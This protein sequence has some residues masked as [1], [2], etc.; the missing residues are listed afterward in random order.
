MSVVVSF[1]E[2][3][4]GSPGVAA[5]ALCILV[6]ALGFYLLKVRP[7][8]QGLLKSLNSFNR[9][10]E[11][12]SDWHGVRAAVASGGS[13]HA[14]VESAWRE[15]QDR[16]LELPYK[17]RSTPAMLSPPTDIWR[18]QRLLGRSM[19]LQL[20]EAAPNILVG[21]GLLFTFFFLTIA[22]TQAAGALV[23][24]A[25]NVVNASLA[26]GGL[27]SAA[28]A[29]F[30]TSLA[31]LLASLIWTLRFKSSV[32]A[33]DAACDRVVD[34]ISR[35]V[36]VGGAEMALFAQFR[37]LGEI[38]K[39]ADE[40]TQLNSELLEEARNQTGA[41]RRFETDF[42]VSLAK[43][44]ESSFTPQFETMTNKLTL[45]IG[46][47]SGKLGAMNQEAL[48]QMLKDFKTMLTEGTAQEMKQ[49]R[50]TLVEL[51]GNLTTAGATVGE[52]LEKAASEVSKA[53]GDLAAKMGEAAAGIALGAERLDAAT[54]E[55][56]VT[57]NDLDSSVASAAAVGKVGAQVAKN[58]I[59]E[60]EPLL[61][62]LAA[63]AEG[64]KEAGKS[65]ERV[66]A[67]LA[68]AVDTVDELT[69]AQRQVIKS[70]RESTP[71]ALNA[72]HRVL[73]QLEGT[74]KLTE[75]KMERAKAAMGSTSDTLTR[76][77]GEIQTG[78]KEYSSTVVKLH[79]DM[80][81][82]LAKA[83]GKLATTIADLEGQLEDFTETLHRTSK[84]A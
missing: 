60:A 36:S 78:I 12:A 74:V 19:N 50:E 28:G 17:S 27:L 9:E 8:T 38:Q 41:L 18:A 59:S 5:I 21:V 76:T 6:F 35:L 4:R 55:L 84:R 73:E 40:R 39:G 31:G 10:L 75:E 63:S 32:G 15:T 20:V 29:K 45:A 3:L 22:L 77:V 80:D 26:T 42:A 71:E 37:Q 13:R 66:S 68:A 7:V 16:V 69:D 83:I 14:A 51:C 24:K 79:Q 34:R 49:L 64:L 72:I 33:I 58:F 82:Q 44:M 23:P 30:L 61:A 54:G 52:G 62:R 81:Q 2:F 48:T 47:L 11:S 67:Q 53:S 1:L 70:V 65:A 57:M 43:A 25:G 46:D 56:K